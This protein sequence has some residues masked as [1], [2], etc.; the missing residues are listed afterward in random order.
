MPF[1]P[2]FR[3]ERRLV[4]RTQCL[5]ESM[6]D[7]QLHR[8][9]G[10]EL[11]QRCPRL[12]GPDSAGGQHHIS[13]SARNAGS[14]PVDRRRWGRWV[15]AGSCNRNGLVLNGVYPATGYGFSHSLSL[16]VTDPFRWAIDSD[17]Q[18]NVSN[19]NSISNACV[20]TLT[21]ASKTLSPAERRGLS[22]GRN[23]YGR[24]QCGPAKLPV[25]GSRR[26]LVCNGLRQ[27]GQSSTSA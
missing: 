19:P 15:P 16:V 20:V 1:N 23:Y 24:L 7:G 6:G 12:P 25:L 11:C 4:C 2:C 5:R 14:L 18:V 13:H 9:R 17:R 3:G 21:L 27:F 10:G 22:L 26:Y 8:R